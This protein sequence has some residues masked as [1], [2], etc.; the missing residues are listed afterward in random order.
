MFASSLR[1]AALIAGAVVFPGSALT[2]ETATLPGG[3][4]SLN[5]THGDWTV[6]CATPEGGVRC[7]ISQTQT[8]GQNGQRVLA[9][10]L[11]TTQEDG[12]AGILVLPFGLQLDKGVELSLDES[13]TATPHGFSTCLPVGCLVP[14]TFDA[15]TAAGLRAGAKLLVKATASDTA[16]DINF[17][18]SLNGFGAALDRVT[19]L[20]RP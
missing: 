18:I 20:S 17:S 6:T 1:I 5:E 7:T 2:Q 10:E 4:S 16:K 8:S 13:G 14:L 9:I 11:H 3:A 15:K 12:T 19:A